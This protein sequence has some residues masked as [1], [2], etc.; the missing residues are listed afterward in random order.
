MANHLPFDLLNSLVERRASAVDEARAQ[1]HLVS[2]GRCRS[3]LEW[4]ERI[5]TRPG[6]GTNVVD[7][8]GIAGLD[9]DDDRPG[10]TNHTEPPSW[11]IAHGV[12]TTRTGRAARPEAGP[13]GPREVG[14]GQIH[15]SWLVRKPY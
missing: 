11:S 3:E 10:L 8:P 13:G 5:R 12:R 7:L 9:A 6:S 14:A 4:L 15:S 1:R 2:C